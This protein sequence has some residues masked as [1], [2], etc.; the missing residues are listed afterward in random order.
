MVPVFDES[1]VIGV[2]YDRLKQ[3]LTE[4]KDFDHEIVFV[5]DGS[6]DDSYEKLNVIAAADGHVSVIKLS[7]N[8]GHQIAITAGIDYVRGDCVVIIDADLQDPPEV[9]PEMIERWQQ[10]FDVVYGVRDSRE[11][12]TKVKLIT[13]ALFYR[14]LKAVTRV[15]IPCDTGDFRL[16]SQRAAIELKKLREKDR[17]VRGLVSWIGFPQSALHYHRDRRFSGK[18]KYPFRKMIRFAADALTSFSAV[19]LKIATWLGYLASFLAFA[20]L[21]SV[22]VQKIMGITVQGWATIMVAMLFLGGTQLICL[23]IIGEYL[24]RVFYESKGRT[25]YVVEETLG[26]VERNG[27]GLVT[28]PRCGAPKTAGRRMQ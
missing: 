20:Y 19:P 8:F 18:T 23:G 11:G 1:E 24:V 5:D 17:F 10:G 27:Q 2:F 15:E 14:L 4:I 21:A 7:R 26:R 25:L 12:E 22:F 6:S 9:I 3:V 13:A 16:M 28:C